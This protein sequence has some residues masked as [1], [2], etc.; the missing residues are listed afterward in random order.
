[1]VSLIRIR[2]AADI[3]VSFIDS[4]DFLPKKMD[5]RLSF[6]DNKTMIKESENQL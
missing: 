4:N 6:A 2:E 5:A 1:M 3:A